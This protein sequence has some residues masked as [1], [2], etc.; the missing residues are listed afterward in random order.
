M[1]AR[2][3]NMN[4]DP[5]LHGLPHLGNAYW[6]PLW[7]LCVERDM[8]VHFHIGASDE[9]SSWYGSGLWPGAPFDNEDIQLVYGSV[10][11]ITSNLRVLANILLS[12]FLENF[13][14]LKI[15]SV[16][17]GIGWV[18]F[19]LEALEYQ[20]A[21]AGKQ[22]RH[23]PREVF[24][25]QMYACSWFERRSFAQTARTVGIDNVMFETDFPHPTCL[26]PN[27][28]DYVAGAIA[29]LT[30]EE[31]RKVFGGTAARIYNLDLN[32]VPPN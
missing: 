20:L 23:S 24:Q 8:P 3:I 15:V 5:H 13:P 16:E 28:L 1:G 30:V 31:R 21:E 27:G 19:L 26:Y 25:R 14:T 11:V 12:G 9:S 10:M 6:N 2:G 18:P 7:E 29:D 4:S 32:A 17:S 22:H